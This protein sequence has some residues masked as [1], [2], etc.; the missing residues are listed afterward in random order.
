MKILQLTYESLGS[1]FGF[2]GAGVRAYKIYK[3]LK[4]RHDITLLC[5]KYPGVKDCEIEGLRH[6]F[7]GTESS[8]RTMN[9]FAY[10]LKAAGFIKKYGHTYDVIV[11]NFLPATPYF[12]RLLTRTPVILQIQGIMGLH[13]LRKYN[14]LYGLPM[15]IV[16]KIYPGLYNTFIFAGN[17]NIDPEERQT[18]LQRTAGRGKGAIRKNKRKTYAVIPNGI[19]RELL[20]VRGQEEKDYILFLSRI[21]VYTKG[22]DTLM[23]AFRLLAGRFK[24]IRLYLAGYEF[25]ST[26]K[27]FQKL[28]GELRGRVKYSGF[29]SGQEKK[30]LFAGARV[31]VLPSRHEAHPVSVLE[32][33]ACGKAVLVSDIPE[34]RYIGDNGIGLTF[35]SGSSQDLFEKLSLLLENTGLRRTLGDKGR[36]YASGLLWDEIA[37]KFERFLFEV[38]GR[39]G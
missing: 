35:R 34:L 33:M 25:N 23:D 30:E 39:K 24:D 37:L 12:S 17:E 38:A 22:L 21:D 36:V 7:V 15:Y 11:E 32:A 3:R 13:S 14:P 8:S 26:E 4:D 19:D 31:V 28:P 10:T 2:G 29:V 18:C 5:L 6:I 20:S 27:L 9:V 16:E 1:P